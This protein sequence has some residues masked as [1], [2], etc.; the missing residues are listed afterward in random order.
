MNK[1]KIAALLVSV[2]LLLGCVFLLIND[3]KTEV[4]E[5][6]F[7]E[8]TFSVKKVP[9]DIVSM[10]LKNSEGVFEFEKIDGVWMNV[11]EGGIKTYGNTILALESIAKESLALDKIEENVASMNKYGLDIPQATLNYTTSGGERG[12]INIGNSIIGTKYYFTVN[13]F[14]VYTMDVSEAGLFMA[15]MAAFADMTLTDTVIENVRSVTLESGGEK[16]VVEKK[17]N[18]ELKEGTAAALFS[19]ALRSPV[20]ENASPEDI[21]SLFEAIA[22]IRASGYYPNADD[23]EC[24]F[25]GSTRGFS[26]DA[27]KD[28]GSF[29]LGNEAGKG[30]TYVKKEGVKGAYK[31]SDDEIA[32]MDYTAFDLVDKH[33]ALFYF[34][35]V[36]AITIEAPGERYDIRIGEGATVNG[37]EVALEDVQEFFR[38]LISLSYEGS[39]NDGY[40]GAT[41]DTATNYATDNVR[42]SFELKDRVDVTEYV[43][44]DAMYYAVQRNGA[45]EFIIQRKF[46]EKII[47]LIKEL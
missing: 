39:I 37:K 28:K 46:I 25:I 3:P 1:V 24:G 26:Y 10:T 32:F 27:G 5:E 14:D 7:K 8:M 13:G 38:S 22:V 12:F 40:T 33:I 17:G 20:K 11:F 21:Q 47:S 2:I 16:V 36:K 18:A 31:V 30:Y 9:G 4:S 43:A 34:E 23:A 45:K 42:I 19:Y 6:E 29:I 41:S 15:G 35:E 44:H